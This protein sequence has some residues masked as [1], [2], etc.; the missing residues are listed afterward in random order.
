M[1]NAKMLEGLYT[2][3]G[4]LEKSQQDAI[5]KFV[6]ENVNVAGEFPMIETAIASLILRIKEDIATE[7]A[8]KSGKNNQL[9]AMKNI[10]KSAK[11]LCKTKEAQQ[12]VQTIDGWQYACDGFTLAK[13]NHIEGLPE[14]PDSLEFLNVGNLFN[15]KSNANTALEMPDKNKLKVFIKEHKAMR[16]NKS[17]QTIYFNFGENL[18]LVNAEWLLNAMDLMTGEYKV[19][20]NGERG[21]LYFKDDNENEVLLMPIGKRDRRD[22]KL[23]HITE[24]VRTE[25]I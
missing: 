10:L 22:G 4:T 21:C 25:L 8:K 19:Y 20:C 7:E 5:T 1:T 9:K 13:I 2:I 11:K 12:F 14:C 18:P 6:K 24:D 15:Q 23:S 16:G 17:E 3:A